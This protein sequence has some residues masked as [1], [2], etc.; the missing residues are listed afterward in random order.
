[1]VLGFVAGVDEDGVEVAHLVAQGVGD[2]VAD[3]VAFGHGELPVYGDG[4]ELTSAT[5]L[6]RVRVLGCGGLAFGLVPVAVVG[7]EQS[8]GF[9]FPNSGLKLHRKRSSH[10]CDR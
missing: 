8:D 3:G 9:P 2:L 6:L 7:A 10:A 4:P 5:V 1:M